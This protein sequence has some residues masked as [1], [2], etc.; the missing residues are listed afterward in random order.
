MPVL[1]VLVHQVFQDLQELLVPQEHQAS[2]GLP[3]H[4]VQLE[5]LVLLD[6]L[7]QVLDHLVFLDLQELL[8]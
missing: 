1:V 6:S 7:T 8:D 4:Q 3:V 2:Q 5:H